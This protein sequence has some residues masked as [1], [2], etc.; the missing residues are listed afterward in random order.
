MSTN[1]TRT[2]QERAEELLPTAEDIQEQFI[3][4]AMLTG[5][6]YSRAEAIR[7]W[8]A[9][10]ER[11]QSARDAE[12]DKEG[13]VLPGCTGSEDCPAP[14]HQHGCFADLQAHCN[15]PEAHPAE[16][17][18]VTAEQKAQAVMA[19]IEDSTDVTDRGVSTAAW[20][21]AN[22]DADLVFRA[23]GFRIEGDPA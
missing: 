8:E 6:A 16:P 15:E 12:Q 13:D 11:E 17:T 21:Q 2:P 3:S 22:R 1:D 20:H 9:W 5:F 10:R 18:T 23:A 7:D 19:L 4:G 14:A